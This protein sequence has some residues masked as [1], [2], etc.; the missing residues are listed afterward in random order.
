MEK[1]MKGP[2]VLTCGTATARKIRACILILTACALLPAFAGTDMAPKA[3]TKSMQGV[4]PDLGTDH[5]WTVE[6]GSGAAWSNVRSGQPNQAYTLVPIDLTASLKVDD[7]SLDN[8]LGGWLRGYTEFYF[9]GQY[10][11][12]VHGPENHVEGFMVGPRYNF[13][14]PGWRIIPYVEGGVGIGFADSNPQQGGL[15]QDFNFTF[16]AG[17]GA[18]Y[19][20][21]DNWF[22]R[23]GVTYQHY[24]N[25]GLSDPIPNHPIDELGPILSVGYG[26]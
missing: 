8:F 26:F 18:K 25:A 12:I 7:V 20:I 5:D 14:Q 6:L 4:T 17:A 15:G 23:L 13:V 1:K 24:S 10:Q 19:V 2:T 16:S 11:Q 9:E 21:N 22:L 3:D